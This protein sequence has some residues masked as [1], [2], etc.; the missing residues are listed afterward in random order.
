MENLV[1]LSFGYAVY[2]A[3]MGFKIAREGWNGNGMFVYHV[4][5]SNHP[6]TTDISKTEFGE[7]VPYGEY[8]AMKTVTGTVVPWL[9]SQTDILAKDWKVIKQSQV[10]NGGPCIV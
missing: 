4:P 6:A 9:A 10:L 2:A 3:E 5:A 1:N 7:Q 8:L